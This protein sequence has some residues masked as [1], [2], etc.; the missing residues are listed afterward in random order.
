VKPKTPTKVKAAAAE[1]A[2]EEDE[3]PERDEL[4]GWPHLDRVKGLRVALLGGE[5]RE[6]R[7]VALEHAFQFES[8]E[9][10]PTDRPRLAASLAERAARGTLD[11]ILVTKFVRHK[12]TEAIERSSQAPVLSLRHGYGVTTVRHAFEDYFTRVDDK[13]TGKGAK[14]RSG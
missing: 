8:L 2:A 11:F 13:T 10:V 12:E 1:E 3:A 6:E 7:R 4:A 5:V 9:W 14:R